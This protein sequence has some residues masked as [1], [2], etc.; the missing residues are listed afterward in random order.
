MIW[1]ILE[2]HAYSR[3]CAFCFLCLFLVVLHMAFRIPNGYLEK[4]R[5]AW[6]PTRLSFSYPDLTWN[7]ML[8]NCILMHNPML[9]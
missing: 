2:F 8:R 7:K 4:P 5:K 6:C 3:I 9:Y 1:S